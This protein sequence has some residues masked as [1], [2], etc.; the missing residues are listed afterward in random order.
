[1]NLGFG[2][3]VSEAGRGVGSVFVEVCREQD[4]LWS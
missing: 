2:F 3:C 1:M 4:C